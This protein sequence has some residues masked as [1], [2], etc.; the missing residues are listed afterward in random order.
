MS[1]LIIALSGSM[2]L[3][4]RTATAARIALEGAAEAGARTELLTVRDLDLPMFDDREDSDSYPL[5]VASFLETVQR[6][7]GFILATPVYHGTISG[8]LKN[9]LDFLHLAGRNAV[10]GKTAGLVSVAGGGVGTNALNTLDYVAR[11]L[12]L[13]T[14]PTTVAAGGSAFADAEL[15]DRGIAERLRAVGQQVARYG[16]LFA[17]ERAA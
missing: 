1:P 17:E 11:S 16:A 6:A 2:G 4:S 7:D 5:T 8:S 15:R 12:R 10:A 14:V 9:A 3:P 13:W